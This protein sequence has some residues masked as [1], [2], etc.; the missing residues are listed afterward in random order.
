MPNLRGLFEDEWEH[1][2]WPTP[3]Q[4]RVPLQTLETPGTEPAAKRNPVGVA[5]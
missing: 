2:W 3:V 4:G 1:E 5:R